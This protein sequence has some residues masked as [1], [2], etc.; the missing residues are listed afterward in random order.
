MEESNVP[1]NH[2]LTAE[3]HSQLEHNNHAWVTEKYHQFHYDSQGRARTHA[4][5][6]PETPDRDLDY[7]ATAAQKW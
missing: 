5:Q 2:S 6:R 7:N 3:E 4:S 1:H